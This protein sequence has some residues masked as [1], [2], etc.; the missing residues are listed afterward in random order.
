MSNP[1]IA[2]VT[3]GSIVESRHT[4][5]FA[6]VDASGKL[7]SSQG[8][9]GTLV[10]PRSAIK[11]FQC[12]PL[13]ES[14]G[15]DRF[16]LV[17][18]ELAL[19]CASH[20]G[21]TDHVRVARAI[22]AKAG[23]TEDDYE[24]GA[25]WPYDHD[26]QRK[27]IRQDAKP[28]PVHNNCSGKHAGMIALAVQMGIDPSGYTAIDHSVQK[29]M[30]SAI[31]RLCQIDSSQLPWGVDGCSVPT[32]AMPLRAMALGFAN[33]TQMPHGQRILAA[34]RARPWMVAGTGRFD[35]RLMEAVPRAFVKVGAEGVYGACVAHA[36]LGIALKCDDGASRAAEVAIGALLSSLGVWEPDERKAL[37]S[38]AAAEMRNWRKIPVGDVHAIRF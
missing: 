37:E 38:F 28:L 8:D 4:G 5:A 31:G 7:L 26:S 3:R 6:V 32:W 19:C 11:A 35:T 33:L 21:E 16:G 24:C 25:H 27:L 15:A 36:G 18:E 1:V 22:L 14:G 30:V 29:Q 20:S 13:F 10:Y 12:L 34:V 2:E 17:D 9:V 23:R